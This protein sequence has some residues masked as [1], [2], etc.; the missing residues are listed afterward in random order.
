M[1]IRC[2][3]FIKV[4][5]TPAPPPSSPGAPDGPGGTRLI[6]DPTE[7]QRYTINK[8]TD[9]RTALTRG[10]KEYLLQLQVNMEGRIIQFDQVF[11]TYPDFEDGARYPAALV[12]SMDEGVYDASKLTVTPNTKTRMP[13]P[14]EDLYL[15]SPAEYVLMIKIEMWATDAVE[16]AALCAMLED[17]MS[18]VLYIGSGVRLE[19]PHYHSTRA[20]YEMVSHTYTDGDAEAMRRFRVATMNVRGRVPVIRVA[21]LVPARMRTKVK[22]VAGT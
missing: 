6:V 9:A 13:S 14:D 20:E 4:P 18:P 7:K 10:L 16:R 12:H 2:T 3:P 15:V 21:S 1:G 11:D 22:V 5:P 17:A 19:L 8:E